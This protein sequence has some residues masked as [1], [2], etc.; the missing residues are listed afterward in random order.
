MTKHVNP[1][2]NSPKRTTPPISNQGQQSVETQLKTAVQ[3]LLEF[4]GY[5]DK[6]AQ[7]EIPVFQEAITR[8]LKSDFIEPVLMRD[9]LSR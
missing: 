5:L 7:L 1:T 4:W 6:I 8:S 9:F 3:Y 2:P